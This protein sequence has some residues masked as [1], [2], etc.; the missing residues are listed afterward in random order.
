MLVVKDKSTHEE[1]LS[2]PLQTDNYLV[3]IAITFLTGFNTTFNITSR[4]VLFKSTV[5][6]ID[7]GFSQLTTAPGAYEK[8]S[9]N[10]EVK[11][12]IIEEG[13]FSELVYPFTIKSNFRTLGLLLEISSNITISQVVK[14]LLLLMRV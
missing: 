14:L 9:L 3:K 4:N 6:I 8:E 13:Y 1:H 11:R 7:D 5:S 2:Q 10:K 12:I